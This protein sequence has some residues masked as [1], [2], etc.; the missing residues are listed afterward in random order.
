VLREAGFEDQG[1][2][3]EWIFHRSMIRRWCELWKS[4]FERLVRESDVDVMAGVEE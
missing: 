1:R 4:V 3:S 2:F